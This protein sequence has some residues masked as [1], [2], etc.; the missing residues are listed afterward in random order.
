MSWS[1]GESQGCQYSQCWEEGTLSAQQFLIQSQLDGRV[2][3]EHSE[4]AVVMMTWEETNLLQRWRLQTVEARR[5]GL[6]VNVAT[7]HLLTIAGLSLFT[8][9]LEED[10]AGFTTIMAEGGIT[11]DDGAGG[12]GAPAAL[13]RGWSTEEGAGVGVWGQHGAANQRFKLTPLGLDRQ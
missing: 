3:E 11:F 6:I 7:G 12:A 5:S 13:D 9:G 4:G 8:P 1:V 2:M 10:E